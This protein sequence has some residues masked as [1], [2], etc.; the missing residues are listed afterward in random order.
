MEKREALELANELNSVMKFS[1]ELSPNLKTNVRV[2]QILNTI[3]ES[4]IEINRKN[5]EEV[6][7]QLTKK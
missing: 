5:I 4:E 7:K 2:A 1:Q 3:L 6:L